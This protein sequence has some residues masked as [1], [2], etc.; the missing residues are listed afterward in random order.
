M[1]TA[2]TVAP[3]HIVAEKPA[4]AREFT[5]RSVLV[6]IVVAAVIGGSYPY[7]VLKLGFGPNISVVSAFFGYLALGIAARNFHRWEN[8]I[9]QTAGTSAGQT[10]FLCTLMAAFDLLSMDPAANF[11]YVLQPHQAFMWLTCSGVLG[12]LLSVPMRQHFVVDEKLTFADGVAAAETLVVLD[13]K[14]GESRGAARS[15]AIGSVLSGLLMTMREDARLLGQVWYRIP[16]MFPLGALG[17]KMN[18]GLSWSLLS[19]GSGLLVGMRINTSMVIGMT[20]AWVIAPPILVEHGMVAN[21]VR[22]EVQLWIL[23]PA[24]GCLVAGGLTTLALRWR[25]LAKSFRGLTS[26]T[27]GSGEFPMRWVIWGSVASAIALALVQR[28]SLGMPFGLTAIAIVLSIPLM[29]VGIRVLGETNWGPISALTNMMQGI[30][31]AVAP[32]SMM[33]NLTASGVTGSVASQSEGLMQD[34]KTGHLIGS[35]PKFLT[36]AQL[37]AVPVGAAAVAFVYPLLRDTYGIGGEN[38]LQSP[39][40]QR[41]AGLARILSA[42][43]H[44][45]PPGAALALLVG[46]TVGVLLTLLENTPVSRRF[47]P[48]PTG[49][50]IGMLVPGSAVFTMFVGGLLGELWRMASRKSYELHV[51]PLA[52]GFIAGEAIVAVLIPILVVVGLVH[53]H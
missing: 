37:I 46:V 35:T 23:W 45:L 11:H 30:F 9:V 8:N 48:S 27:V 49:I 22:R 39:I 4:E 24:V 47:V 15:M 28:F 2:E 12:V 25:V 16:E 38:G 14:G 32:G 42:G 34:Y 7:I 44:A 53:L 33:F 10:A 36:Y 41:F 3:V 1:S 51:T 19:M 18:V 21:L 17:A 20:I 43:V 5:L 26:A 50:G 29:L 31:G 52:S 40:S 6:A 13:G